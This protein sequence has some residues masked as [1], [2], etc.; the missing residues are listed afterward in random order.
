MQEDKQIK[1]C[2]RCGLCA[3]VC[4][5][6]EV[7][8]SEKT[9][10]R[11][12]FL[13]LLGVLKG[14]LILNKKIR[15]NIN[16]CLNCSKCTQNCPSEI[17]T[18]ELFASIKHK[19]LSLI[20]KILNS[21][22]V[23]KLK[24]LPIG[25]IFPPNKKLSLKKGEIYFKGCVPNYSNPGENVCC[26]LPY[27]ASGNIEAANKMAKRNM[28]IIENPQ[29]KKVYFD[30]ASCL[31]TVA[32]YPFKDPETIEKLVLLEPLHFPENKKFSIH[33]PCHMSQKEF[34]LLEET[35]QV[36]ENYISAYNDKNFKCC[37]LGGTFFMKH[38]LVALELCLRNAQKFIDLKVD[39]V[40]SPCP[41]CTLSLRFGMWYKKFIE[42][43]SHNI[44]IKHY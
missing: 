7:K 6:Y 19:N 2:T 16:F 20:E 44:K 15:D 32:N 11:G 9:I 35:L 33:K 18:I 8:P 14:D 43:T 25:F 13:Q 10:A 23:F 39:Y 26:G 38:P 21:R 31:Q 24:L 29:V 37:G 1:K 27:K 4:P 5:L 22:F 12:K 42:R 34:S 17:N 36:R 30:C 40:L 3:S 28:G 41:V